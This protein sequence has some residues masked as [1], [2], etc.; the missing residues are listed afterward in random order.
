MSLR[1]EWDERKAASNRVKH[2]V[3]FE[4][5]STVFQDVR[6]RIF[7]DEA[8]SL[9]EKREIIV[10]HSILNRVLLVSF[11]ERSRDVVR[12]ISARLASRTERREYEENT[13]AKD[14]PH[15]G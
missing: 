1:F 10:G 15:D 11:T 12:I 14:S 5:A 7:D 3:S 13:G 4:E 8:H 9:V 6:A 2:K